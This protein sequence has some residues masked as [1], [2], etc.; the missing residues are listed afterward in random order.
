MGRQRQGQRNN[1]LETPLNKNCQRKNSLSNLL[2]VLPVRAV[3]PTT[4]TTIT[5]P[6]VPSSLPPSASLVV[7]FPRA[8]HLLIRPQPQC[9]TTGRLPI[10]TI[11]IL[12]PPTSLTETVRPHR[13]LR[14]SGVLICRQICLLMEYHLTNLDRQVMVHLLPLHPTVQAWAHH[15]ILPQL[16]LWA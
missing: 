4:A 8:H 14:D 6:P 12:T 9:H 10:T 13:N 2:V 1:R 11:P 15:R 3:R 5:L 16:I 7:L